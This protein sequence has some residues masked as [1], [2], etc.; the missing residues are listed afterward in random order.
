MTTVQFVGGPHDGER[1]ESPPADPFPERLFKIDFRDGAKYARTGA[2]EDDALV[3][4]FDPDGR[5][6][7]RARVT[8]G[9]L[10]PEEPD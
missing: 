3:F 1:V 8:F 9:R 7:R 10:P 2:A 5:L 4:A 6:T